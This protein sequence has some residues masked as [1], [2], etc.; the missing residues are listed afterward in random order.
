MVAL[1]TFHALFSSTHFLPARCFPLTAGRGFSLRI[2]IDPRYLDGS[3]S[4]IATYSRRLIEN[5]A[6]VDEENEYFVFVRPSFRERLEVGPNFELLTYKPR[7]ISWQ[8]YFELHRFVNQIKPDLLHSL[9]PHAPVFFRGPLIVTV[10][11]MQPFTDPD[12]SAKRFRLFQAA[13]NLFYRWAY[14]TTIAQAEWVLCDSYATRED[15]KRILP[16]AHDKLVVVRPGLDQDPENEPTEGLVESIQQKVGVTGRYF[17]YYGSTRPNKNLAA[18]VRAFAGALS[19][20]EEEGEPQL[21]DVKLVLVVRKDRFFRDVSRAIHQTRLGNRVVVTQPLKTS[22]QEAL[23]SGALAFAFPT[24]FEG[25]GFPPLEAMR[26]GVPVLGGD[27]GSLPEVLEDAA[28]LA[29]PDSIEDIA[30]K[31]LQLGRDEELRRNLIDRGKKHIE[32]FDWR[33]TASFITEIYT[34][35]I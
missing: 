3:Y 31:M 8:S 7:P 2:V 24:K 26:A 16:G 25:F 4:G 9:A 13:Y 27:S 22:E 12:F 1:L 18:L 33:S 28:L 21:T 32:Q 14:P 20:D 19:L 17:L 34:R 5:I 15:V 30:E 11:D 29:D 6:A 10:H 23:L 35:L